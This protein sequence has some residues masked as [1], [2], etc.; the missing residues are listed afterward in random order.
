MAFAVHDDGAEHTTMSFKHSDALQPALTTTTAHPSGKFWSKSEA[1]SWIAFLFLGTFL[2]YCVRVTLPICVPTMAEQFAW[3]K[4][5]SGI[6][7][8][9]FFWGYCLT[10]IIGGHISDR[11]GGDKILLLSAT[12]WGSV[13]TLTPL[14]VHWSS[15][16]IIPLTL[17]RFLMGL[18]QG[19]FFPS[20]TSL[21][22]NKVREG[23]RAFTSSA[24]C[25]GSQVGTLIIGAVGSVLL[26]WYGWESVFY[27]SGL[28]SILWAYCM[29][30]YFLKR[31]DQIISLESLGNSL[32]NSKDNKVVWR[33]LFRSAPVWAVSVAHVCI[34]GTFFCL[35]SW[36]PTFFHDSFPESKGWV[37]N[38]VPWAVGVPFSL[39]GGTLADHLINLGFDTAKVRKSMQV[40]AMGLS[41]IFIEL[42][43]YTDN[44]Y[45]ALICVSASIGLQTFSHSGVSVNVQDL[46]PSCAGALFGVMNTGGALAGV[47][48]VYFAGYLIETSGSWPSVFNLISVVNVFGLLIF[49]TFGQ[50]MRVDI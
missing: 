29:W 33:K 15:T 2:V 21:L 23:D 36:M 7:L 35:L 48:L 28:P 43:K 44:Y 26:D 14:I 50:A 27:F 1:K 13:I 47:F 11:L 16:P 8:G 3:D 34:S 4:K 46:A 20:L 6:V 49:I 5:Q 19:V 32:V 37:F 18:L 41:S 25:S 39:F 42:L 12:S 31:E 38:A 45:Q 10:Q 30:K 17:S 9:S 40:I 24:V 22:S